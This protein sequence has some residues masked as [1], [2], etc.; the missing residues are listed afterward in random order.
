MLAL[1]EGIA[2]V[3]SLAGRNRVL[4]GRV[5]RCAR[6]VAR[7]LVEGPNRHL[8]RSA[9]AVV[10][11]VHLRIGPVY[12][13]FVETACESRCDSGLSERFP[14]ETLPVAMVP[15]RNN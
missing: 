10:L 6:R 3:G 9:R 14:S 1:G 15:P 13:Q 12:R 4:R 11:R 7:G 5:A 2:R 8:P